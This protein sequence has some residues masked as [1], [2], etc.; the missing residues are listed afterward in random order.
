M[1]LDNLFIFKKNIIEISD[2]NKILDYKKSI[3]NKAKLKKNFQDLK[4]LEKFIDKV[5]NDFSYTIDNFI[6]F[7]D[8]NSY[9]TLYD[10]ITKEFNYRISEKE[11]LNNL[12][13]LNTK[14]PLI[15]TNLTID[16]EILISLDIKTEMAII[17]GMICNSE[18]FY[19]MNINN[20]KNNI[21]EFLALLYLHMGINE[22]YDFKPNTILNLLDNKEVEYFS[23]LAIVILNAYINFFNKFLPEIINNIK[24]N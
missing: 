7:K 22:L 13:L 6:S 17:Y 9:N 20:F 19:L 3:Y 15:K 4:F 5:T 11:P 8:I 2:S 14:Y 23:K 16:K 1:F 24:N 10:D 18:P 12:F 21:I